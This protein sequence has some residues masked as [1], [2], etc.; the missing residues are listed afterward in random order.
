VKR[1]DYNFYLKN[2]NVILKWQENKE[3]AKSSKQNASFKK[4]GNE[5]LTA[6]VFYP[7]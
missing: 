5:L 4:V 3:S 6:A 2:K 1:D 7:E